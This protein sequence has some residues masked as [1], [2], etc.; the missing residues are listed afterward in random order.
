MAAS[1]LPAQRQ[2]KA[3]STT[4]QPCAA[5][6][7][8]FTFERPLL[9]GLNKT[10]MKKLLLLAL[11]A[12]LLFFQCKVVRY[13][14]EKLPVKQIMFG[15]GGGYAN[16]ETT[17]TLLENGQ[18]FKRTGNDGKYEELKPMKASEA[19]QVFE[20]VASLQ[21]YKLDIYKPGN[22]YYFLQDANAKTDS[23]IVWGAGDF[24]P[25]KSVVSVFRDLY[26]TAKQRETIGEGKSSVVNK[27]SKEAEKE[28]E[29]EA[30]KW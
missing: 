25:P 5:N 26:A 6:Q 1:T 10:S 8:F 27:E 22:L 28:K 4:R 21:L 23:R 24:L 17:Y 2:N 9:K 15:D 20:K 29:I 13:T 19:K 16:L 30:G 11:L 14:P 3:R 18:L 12:P 7:K